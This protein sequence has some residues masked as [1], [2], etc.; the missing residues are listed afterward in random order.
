MSI[1]EFQMILPGVLDTQLPSVIL[2]TVRP[3]I[4][5]LAVH[6]IA[7]PVAYILSAVGPCI[8]SKAVHSI[9]SPRAIIRVA[10]CPF[11]SAD[12]MSLSFSV[13]AHVA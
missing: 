8:R 11:V 9:I 12:S 4:N 1:V 10:I 2:A 7:L 5:A 3:R 13:V 6:E